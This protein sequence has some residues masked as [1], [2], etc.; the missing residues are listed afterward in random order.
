MKFD[1]LYSFSIRVGLDPNK[2]AYDSQSRTGH[3]TY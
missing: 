1:V 3:F 2:S